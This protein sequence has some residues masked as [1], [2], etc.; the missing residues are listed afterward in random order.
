VPLTRRSGPRPGSRLDTTMTYRQGN[1]DALELPTARAR[2]YPATGRRTLDAAVVPRCP[3]CRR[4]HFHRGA[5]LDGAVR[6][7]SCSPR[8]EYVLAVIR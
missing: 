5:R 4:T 8:R 3:W 7:S 2:L 1:P 6:E